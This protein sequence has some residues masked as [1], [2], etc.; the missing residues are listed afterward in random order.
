MKIM[1]NNLE[2]LKQQIETLLELRS[3][4]M[5]EN[6]LL[7]KK[8]AEM[9]QESALLLRKKNNVVSKLQIIIKRLKEELS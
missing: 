5:S 3:Q 9:T 7:H 6:M 8:L 2:Q 4:L 1:D